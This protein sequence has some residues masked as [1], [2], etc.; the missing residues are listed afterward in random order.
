MTSFKKG[1][2]LF[3]EGGLIFEGRP[4]YEG[5]PILGEIRVYF[6]VRTCING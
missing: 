5:G 4:I 1:G 6:R 2:G 3:F